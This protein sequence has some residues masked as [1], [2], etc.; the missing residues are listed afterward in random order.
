[1]KVFI[2]AVP[3]FDS[4]M[5]VQAYRLCDRSGE[6]AIGIQND[7]R[8]MTEALISPGLD[9][10]EK[11]GLE[12]FAGDK[13]LFTDVNQFKLLTEAL[14][15][16]S[17]DPAKLVCVL[18]G[19]APF[20]DYALGKCR[21][22]R[23]LGYT[24]ALDSFPAAGNKHPLI[25]LISYLLMDY[26]EPQFFAQ[27]KT[28]NID[29]PDIRPIITNI[30]DTESYQVLSRNR[31]ALFTGGF[32]NQP[33]TEGIKEIS[34]VKVNALQLLNQVNSKDF[35]FADVSR[36]IE[37]DP[38]LTI[39]LLRFINSAAVG[40]SNKVESIHSAV[41]LLGQIEV[42][43]WATVAISVSLAEDRP[44]EITKLSLTRAKLAEN[45]AGPFGLSALQS[46]LFLTGLFS[47]LDVILEKPMVEAIN[48]VAVDKWVREALVEKSGDL[49]AVLELIYTYERA[50]WDKVSILIIKKGISLDDVNKAF[51]D[52]I[53]WYGQILET[54]DAE[55]NSPKNSDAG[56][57]AAP[58]RR[59]G[60]GRKKSA[61]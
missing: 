34:P 60:D 51:V 35:E 21:R 43:R 39:S 6:K 26:Q 7:F 17:I 52:A 15:Y 8:R 20:D 14:T 44:G 50:D 58:N 23:A 49:A 29:L 4:N 40:L 59:T 25:P 57:S 36:I 30:P 31:L 46:S 55:K 38:Y 32:Y 2:V 28:V 5:A 11:V 1:M 12:P 41:T 33:I 45:L 61:R 13:P 22:L 53:I 10:I 19:Q 3:L 16:M 54:I 9:L 37:R 27:Y 42:R 56:K 18:P 24:L 48:D 47:L